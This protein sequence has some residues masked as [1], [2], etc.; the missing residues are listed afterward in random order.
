MLIGK[1][2]GKGKL[3]YEHDRPIETQPGHGGNA[4]APLDIHLTPAQ[5]VVPDHFDPL[6]G[7]RKG[8][9]KLGMAHAASFGQHQLGV[10]GIGLE[11][12]VDE[13]RIG[14]RTASRVDVHPPARVGLQQGLVSFAQLVGVT[15]QT[16]SLDGEQNRI[17]RERIPV[18]FAGLVTRDWPGDTAGPGRDGTFGIAGALGPDGREFRAAERGGFL[19]RNPSQG[20]RRQSQGGQTE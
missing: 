17:V 19:G 3:L 11:R 8:G 20:L 13:L 5:V 10:D 12:L 2:I 1:T 14:R 9:G 6:L 16:G 7:D 4:I 15:L 18:V